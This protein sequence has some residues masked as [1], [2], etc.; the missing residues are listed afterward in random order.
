MVFS[1]LN[2]AS[3]EKSRAILLLLIVSMSSVIADLNQTSFVSLRRRDLT[4]RIVGGTPAAAREFPSFVWA[5]GCG[6]SLIRSDIV[7]TAAHCA[8]TYESSKVR[9]GNIRLNKGKQYEV[10]TVIVHP[11][12]D[13][14][15]NQNDIAIVKLVCASR[16]PIQKLNFNSTTPSGAAPLIGAGFGTTTFG[17]ALSNVLMKVTVKNI[18]GK[19]CKNRYKGYYPV[20]PDQMICAGA[21]DGGKDTCQGDSGGP[22]YS[23]DKM[24][25]GITSWGKEC[26]SAK[27]PGVYTRISM[28]KSFIE[29]T[30]AAYSDAIP[31]Y[32]Y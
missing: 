30:I 18:P 6:G 16:A 12:Y 29:E 26:A 13:Y 1:T 14:D 7:L 9:I 3:F 32:C 22:L 28:Y 20:F 27:F 4:E 8:D 17:G 11:D 25:V 19:I 5:D 2:T 23:M 24:Q 15:T 31:E 10:E 21:D